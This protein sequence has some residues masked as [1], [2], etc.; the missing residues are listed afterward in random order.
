MYEPLKPNFHPE[1]QG[2][3]SSKDEDNVDIVPHVASKH[4]NELSW[5]FMCQLSTNAQQC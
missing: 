1:E 3:E 4:T 5:C 2:L